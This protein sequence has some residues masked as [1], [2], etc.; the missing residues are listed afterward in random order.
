MPSKPLPSASNLC[1]GPTDATHRR[2][3][4]GTKVTRPV[5]LLSSDDESQQSQSGDEF[6]QSDHSD[7]GSQ[8]TEELLSDPEP[9]EGRSLEE[10]VE[11]DLEVA[12]AMLGLTETLAFQYPRLPC[13]LTGLL[14]TSRVDTSSPGTHLT[15]SWTTHGMQPPSS[16]PGTSGIGSQPTSS[17][18]GSSR[19]STLT[20]QS[21]ESHRSPPLLTQKSLMTH[22][23]NVSSLLPG[24][25]IKTPT[26]T[27]SRLPG[28]TASKWMA[29]RALPYGRPTPKQ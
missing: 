17:S 20:S 3:A 27:S 12:E 23:P 11:E 9:S 4:P 6:E 25:R 7:R 8:H 18:T 10:E 28:R 24:L 26:K 14:T 13:L 15:R 5:E 19:S 29:P 1:P 21:T 2:E 22:M 16:A